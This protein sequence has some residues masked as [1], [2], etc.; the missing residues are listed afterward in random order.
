MGREPCLVLEQC[1]ALKASYSY[2]PSLSCSLSPLHM[3]IWQITPSLIIAGQH[4]ILPNYTCDEKWCQQARNASEQHKCMHLA[5]LS[6]MQ[7]HWG[8]PGLGSEWGLSYLL[9]RGGCP[10]KELLSV[11]GLICKEMKDS[12]SKIVIPTAFRS[13][14]LLKEIKW[15]KLRARSL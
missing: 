1:S 14:T 10:S 15:M 8:T 9:A 2:F 12:I 13:I 11:L 5:N 7:G 3:Q 4:P 6:M